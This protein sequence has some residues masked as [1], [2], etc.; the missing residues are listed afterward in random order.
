MRAYAITVLAAS[1]LFGCASCSGSPDAATPASAGPAPAAGS[2]ALPPDV[3]AIVKAR[4]EKCH[5]ESDASGKLD[6]TPGVAYASL[7]G[8][9]SLQLPSRKIVEP[10]DPDRSYLMD[11][12]L[13]RHKDVGGKG[14]V[15]PKKGGPLEA[16][17]IE[18]IRA[19][20]KSL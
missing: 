7:V 19:W 18:T 15:M 20:I 11:K 17:Q 4:C 6:L 1:L 12:L 8:S 3:A 10:G 2:K 14:A 13:G 16:S 9:P 5:S